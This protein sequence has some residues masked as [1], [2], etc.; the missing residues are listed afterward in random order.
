M[1]VFG[2]ASAMGQT[3]SPTPAPTAAPTAFPGFSATG[4]LAVQASVAGSPVSLGAQI[5]VMH[6]ARRVRIDVL[7]VDLPPAAASGPG[8]A[9]FLPRGAVSIVYDQRTNTTT[10]WSVEK[11]A[12]YQ[13]TSRAAKKRVTP[14]PM[15]NRGSAMD[16]IL[17][18]TKSLTEYDAFNSSTTL[19]GH[20]PINGHT[21]SLFHTIIH[22]Q[23]HDEKAMDITSDLAFADDLSGIPIR[24]W[25]VVTGNVAGSIKLDLLNASTAAPSD[26]VFAVPAGYKR[27]ASLA[28]LF[29]NAPVH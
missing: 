29:S 5:A 7:H 27:V 9:Q 11:R 14:T 19:V 2:A 10:I 20:Q 23:K 8:I 15:P 28:E 4:T 22:S 26:S 21:A 18:F 16:Q 13:K 12:Y 3:S 24:F 17:R 1:V 25:L 6:K